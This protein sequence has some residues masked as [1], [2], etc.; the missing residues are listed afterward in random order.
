M[1]N[2]K[3]DALG[4]TTLVVVVVAA[5]VAAGAFLRHT[6]YGA[7]FSEQNPVGLAEITQLALPVC[8]VA[9]II[10]WLAASAVLEGQRSLKDELAQQR[11]E[12]AALRAA[13]TAAAE[14]DHQALPAGGEPEIEF[15]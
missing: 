13:M 5:G 8:A 2:K 7:I 11:A 4:L 12:L 10:A 6:D 3:A 14:Q 1:R 15:R 9:L